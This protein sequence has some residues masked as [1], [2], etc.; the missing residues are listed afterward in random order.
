MYRAYFVDDEP[1]VLDKI[2]N[3]PLLVES[4]FTVVGFSTDSIKA[5]KEIRKLN[6]NAV[7]TDL[8]MPE[9]TGVDMMEELREGGVLCEFVVISAYPE[10]E[11]SRR[12][13]LMGGFDYLLKPVSDQNLRQLLNRLA[14]KLAGKKHEENPKLDTPSPELNKLAAYLQENMAEQHTL[15]SL[16]EK[17]HFNRSYIS[18]L[19]ANHLGTTFTAYLTMLGWRKQRGYLKSH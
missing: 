15:D 3:N 19:F 8:K 10:F 2:V 7:F 1:L 11:E 5:A 13:F 6:P 12:F 17:Y 14:G 4:G 16:S 18:R 9:R